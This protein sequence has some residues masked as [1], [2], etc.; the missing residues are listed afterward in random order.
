MKIVPK[1]LTDNKSALLHVLAPYTDDEA[2]MTSSNG[3][4]FRVTVHLCGEFTGPRNAKKTV[5]FTWTD[6]DK[7]FQDAKFCHWTT[8]R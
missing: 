7:S 5:M 4:I 2:M 3:N 6:N 1:G 8:I